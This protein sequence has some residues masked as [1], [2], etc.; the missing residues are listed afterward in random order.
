MQKSLVSLVAIGMACVGWGAEAPE[1]YKKLWNT[2]LNANIDARIEKY[3]KADAVARG[4]PP[5]VEVRIEQITHAFQF[6]SHIFNFD[7]LGRDDWNA[8]YRATFTNLWNA[9]TVA[10]YWDKMEVK[11]GEIRYG[12]GPRDTAEFW[13]SVKEMSP[14]EK[15]VR[16]PEY[17]R[18]AP[19]PVIAFL[20]ENHISAH[21]HV[22]IYP[23]FTAPWVTN[24]VGKAGL[25]TR[26]ERR[27]RQLGEYYGAQLDQWDV[28]N[29]TVD[30]ACSMAGPYHDQVVWQCPNLLVPED[31]TFRCHKWAAEAF[32]AS[33]G[34]EVNDSWRP[35]YVPFIQSLIDRGAKIDVVGLQMHIFKASEA[36]R[37][38]AGEPCVA[39]GTDWTP[40]AQFQMLWALDTLKRPIHISEITIPAPDDTAEG[41]EIQARMMRDNYRLW[42]SWPTVYRI[43]YWNLVDHTYH[44]E[45]LASGLYTADMRKKK[46]YH[47]L[48]KLINHEWRTRLTV[49]A[50]SDGVVAFR[51]FKG[52]YRLSWKDSAGHEH[53]QGL[54]VK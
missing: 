10:F 49:K 51:G 28:V 11:E 30:R 19:D 41:E 53:V 27:I 13:K 20:K 18:P 17:R 50:D 48:D 37:I 31:Y 42:F 47:A 44:N 39:N 33:V 3:R 2:T 54:S 25:A 15:W 34:L 9:A 40:E 21:G 32:P 36:R 16:F 1:N 26:Y 22:M 45:N 14:E 6:G 5:G 46:A 23:P 4:L 29:E 35:I 12:A 8:A 38:A 7:Q 43:T 24:G 52:E